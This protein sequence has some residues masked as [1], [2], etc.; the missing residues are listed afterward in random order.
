M[1]F[2]VHSIGVDYELVTF[3]VCS[4][5]LPCPTLGKVNFSP[6]SGFFTKK[7]FFTA[8]DKYSREGP[9]SSPSEIPEAAESVPYRGMILS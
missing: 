9:P 5:M 8:Y 3:Q 7:W 6:E 4:R 1:L 2:L